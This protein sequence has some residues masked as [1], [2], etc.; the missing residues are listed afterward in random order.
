MLGSVA[1]LGCI[2]RR[3]PGS[4]RG[5]APSVLSFTE[6]TAV[7]SIAAGPTVALVG[8]SEGLD[9]FDLAGGAY[10]R[11][12]TTDGVPGRAIL[13]LAPDPSRRGVWVAA[14]GGI[15]RYDLDSGTFARIRPPPV[16]LA[17]AFTK[18]RAIAPDFRGDG[19]FVGG[20][21]G[22][23]H[24]SS[25]GEWQPVGF[26]RS[27]V[28]LLAQPDG[29]LW[30]A[31]ENGV[32]VRRGAGS[33]REFGPDDGLSIERVRLLLEAPDGT[34]VVIGENAEGHQRLAFLV[35]ERFATFRPSPETRFLSGTR[36]AGE[37]VLVS[38]SR[39]YAL[40]PPRF[41]A[42]ILRRD[43]IHLVSETPGLRRAP[44][45]IRPLDVPVPTEPTVVTASGSELFLGTR[46]LGTARL[47]LD[48]SRPA[49]R[50]SWLRRADLVE[51]AIDLSVA[52]AHARECWV[53]TGSSRAWKLDGNRFRAF[54]PAPDE[55]RPVVTL[56]VVR[57]PE[58][59]I[60]SLYR[61]GDESV[62]RIARLEKGTFV[63]M[64]NLEIATPGGVAGL[65]F[66]KFAP[67][68][69]LWLGLRTI[70]EDGEP[71]PFGVAFVD[72]ALRSVFYHRQEAGLDARKT[73]VLPIPNDVND[74]AFLEDETWFAT[75]SG[76]ARLRG[77]DDL[78]VFSEADGLESE[79]LH[80]IVAT[81][82]GMIFVATSRGIGQYDGTAWS[83][84][85]AL[86]G[87][88]HA[89]V[90]G[91]DGRLW[92]GTDRG[93][94]SFDGERVRNF[95][96]RAGFSGGRVEDLAVDDHGRIWARSMEG[97]HIVTP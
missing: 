78:K 66:A 15:A 57:S 54:S 89:I 17:A 52:C 79:I 82:G 83:F 21:A 49:R 45:E 69:L 51:D 9:R 94:A 87:T 63:P 84:P 95:D 41:G 11:L 76:A 92:M 96:A 73:G 27:V 13:A 19:L 29:D 28:A 74:V 8:T 61:I 35:G 86:A 18:L 65:T 33:W 55:T 30:V 39:M 64:Q 1:A 62:V 12:E 24:V 44:Y 14:D 77:A 20:N 75:G 80:G 97:I 90:R 70:D 25:S 56:A 23:Y 68:G 22:L 36:R 81:D 58:R 47:G 5:A 34:P 10:V 37:L 59:D 85:R 42:R 16:G 6:S 50:W 38:Q 32:A 26:A 67:D 91:P 72:L 2:G 3:E 93:L 48:G 31:T 88:V 4:T 7:T 53:A 43:G 46:T 60:L 71:R 40:S